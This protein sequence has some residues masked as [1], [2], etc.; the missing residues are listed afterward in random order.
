M[1][2]GGSFEREGASSI[3]DL[4]R[5][6]G[7]VGPVAKAI[8]T[9]LFATLVVGALAILGHASIALADVQLTMRE[10]RVRL[11]AKDAT[12]RQILTEWARVGQTKIVNAERIPGGPVTLELIDVPEQ[13]ALDVLLRTISGYL[14]APRAGALVNTSVFDRIVVMP[15]SVAPSA[16][17]SS[18]PATFT[19]PTFLQ[20]PPTSDDE[21]DRPS[22]NLPGLNRAPVFVVPPPPATNVPMSPQQLPGL[23]VGQPQVPPQVFPQVPPRL[24]GRCN[25]RCNFRVTSALSRAEGTLSLPRRPCAPPAADPMIICPQV[26]ARWQDGG[27]V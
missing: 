20:R 27:R 17:V 8:P 14:V 1:K 15:T 10:G 7:R 26:P 6:A 4:R 11:I 13:Q 24:R 2:V 12:V 21:D 9:P 18:A 23:G 16:P 19:Q 5:P 22:P 25:S 3:L